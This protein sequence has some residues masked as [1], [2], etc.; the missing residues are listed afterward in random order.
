[1]C[2]TYGT[3]H[4]NNLV[5]YEDTIVMYVKGNDVW[6]EMNVYRQIFD[7]MATSEQTKTYTIGTPSGTRESASRTRIGLMLDALDVIKFQRAALEFANEH[8][9]PGRSGYIQDVL[10]AGL[11]AI[12]LDRASRAKVTA[13]SDFARQARASLVEALKA[14][15]RWKPAHRPQWKPEWAKPGRKPMTFPTHDELV[16]LKFV[17]YFPKPSLM[18]E[19]QRTA[20]KA[21]KTGKTIQED[22]RHLAPVLSAAGVPPATAIDRFLEQL[23]KALD[24]EKK[25]DKKADWDR[26]RDKH[27]HSGLPRI[28]CFA[29]RGDDR[30]PTV[31]REA[32]GFMPGLTRKDAY[33]MGQN[34]VVDPTTMKKVSVAEV[35]DELNTALDHSKGEPVQRYFELLR[36]YALLHLGSHTGDETFRAFIS[37]SKST[38]I[39]KHFANSG[40]NKPAVYTSWCYAVHCR[41]GYELPSH[42]PGL[43]PGQ[44]ARI[45]DLR[46]IHAFANHFEQEVAVAG[47]I[48]W[49]QIVGF[50]LVECTTTGQFF[51]G[52]VYLREPGFWKEIGEEGAFNALFELMSG[53]SQ[54]N[55]PNKIFPSYV[56]KPQ[57]A[58]RWDL[59]RNV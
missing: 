15:K 29:Y 2:T 32:N 36:K 25:A 28:S 51:S 31:L 42:V 21:E 55:A 52:P 26:V 8:T 20:L 47:P 43:P 11:E 16:K 53:K 44:V 1:M 59:I 24:E 22:P 10:D 23:D 35:A 30:W 9:Q 34:I 39:A 5:R 48:W 56:L 45:F 49:D 19:E 33:L 18:R 7:D 38:A 17:G 58:D 3:Y 46:A 13:A 27:L 40:D 6:L 50:R 4:S 37:A 57:T 54:G 12:G 14:A 41:S